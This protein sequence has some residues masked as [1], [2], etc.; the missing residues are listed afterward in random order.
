M[1]V[2]TFD[3][4]SAEIHST[5]DQMAEAFELLMPKPDQAQRGAR[6]EP[7]GDEEGLEWE[8]VGAADGAEG[9]S[10]HTL[11]SFALYNVTR[12][13]GRWEAHFWYSSH[14]FGP[15]SGSVPDLVEPIA[16]IWT[17]HR[18]ADCVDRLILMR[19]V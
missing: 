16:H 3:E 2:E 17:G 6:A 8:D 15:L 9:N 7:A 1:I 12:N 11:H 19:R 18:I 10:H 5:L 13:T 4:T 14:D